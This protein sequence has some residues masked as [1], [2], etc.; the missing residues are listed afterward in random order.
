[1]SEQVQ[2][3]GS[4]GVSLDAELTRARPQDEIKGALW[5]RLNRFFAPKSLAIV[6][7]SEDAYWSRNAYTN[8][9]LIGFSGRIVPVN[10]KRQR[11]FGLDCISTLRQ[12]DTPVD[13]AYIAAPP[14]AIPAILEDAA[15]AGVRNAVIIAAGFGEAGAPGHQLQRNLVDQARRHDITLLG[16]NCPGFLN[17]TDHAAAYGQQIPVGLPRGAVAVVLQSGA[18]T[19]VMLKFAIAHAI[20]LSKV[21]CMGNEAIVQAADVLEHLIADPETRV[22]AMFLEQIRDGARFLSLAR[23]ALMNGKSIVVLKAGRT[24][25]G[26]RAALAHTGA[27]AGDE[28]V[29]DAALRQAG[30]A[31]VR[32][33]EEL[34][35]T[36]GLLAQ[37]YPLNGARMAV[38][39]ASGGACDIIADRAS[40]EGL[41][42]P[43]FSVDTKD[44]LKAYLPGFATIQNPLDTAAIDTV[45][46]TGT[47]A[48]PMDVVAEMVSRDPS[49]DFVIYM[50]FNVV[51]QEEPE[52]GERDRNF[53]RMAHVRTMRRNAPLPLI[54]IGLTCLPNGSFAKRIYHDNGIWILPGIEFG[55]T[56][57]GHAVRWNATRR[58]TE[59]RAHISHPEPRPFGEIRKA[60]LWSEARRLLGTSDVPL[61]PA[62]LV[63]SA[64]A[65]IAAAEELRYPVVLKICAADIAHKSDIGG[66]KLNLRSAAEVRE[67]YVDVSD[68]GRKASRTGIEGVLVSPMRPQ[69]LELFAGVTIDP[70]FGPVLAVGLGGIWIETLKDVSLAVLPVSPHDIE[71]M[72]RSLRARALLEGAR[73]GP[74]IDFAKVAD[75]V[76]RISRAALSL[77]KDLQALEV[78][79]LWCLDDR[80]EALDALVVTGKE[81]ATAAH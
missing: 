44:D 72:L 16:P 78:N 40:D 74:R 8:L 32:S 4:D 11:V 34:L 81:G 3:D 53:A 38:V 48:V 47:A 75:A 79:P 22:I 7:A 80:V 67:A 66:V 52:P 77:G 54:P 2:G 19:T 20:G 30:I 18:L 57:L 9:P 73:G 70:T 61:V 42:M 33:L 5:G 64:D 10:P 76:F 69:G 55:L 46:E 58:E 27:I 71:K 41:E 39:S 62:A 15:A 35:I 37:G 45:R 23:R 56:A 68:A 6:G 60:G 1:M 17:L 63:E 43:A 12:L 13:L 49:F 59:S 65:A 26:Q 21:I 25:A 24:Q 14:S 31:R 29:V 36:A 51:P 28:A 50:G